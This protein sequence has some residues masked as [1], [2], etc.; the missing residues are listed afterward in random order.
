MDRTRVVWVVASFAA[1]VVCSFGISQTGC[2]TTSRNRPTVTPCPRNSIT[3]IS[4][5]YSNSASESR[6]TF[7]TGKKCDTTITLNSSTTGW[8]GVLRLNQD[9]GAGACDRSLVRGD[10][11]A[12]FI[13][14]TA[15]VV[16]PGTD[17]FG[18][19][20]DTRVFDAWMMCSNSDCTNAPNV[21]RLQV[22][23]P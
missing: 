7:V 6:C 3:S 18:V 16:V 12:Q 2:T 8:S 11:T 13:G 4:V 22:A 14:G 5:T 15:T 9:Q 1:L 23:C 19:T 21:G 17:S 20:C 10:Y